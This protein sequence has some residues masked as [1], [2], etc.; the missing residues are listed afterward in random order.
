MGFNNCILMSSSSFKYL[1]LYIFRPYFS[2]CF[3][4]FSKRDARSRF[5]LLQGDS[6]LKIE[7]VYRGFV[8]RQ[9]CRAIRRH[10]EELFRKMASHHIFLDPQS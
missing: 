6:A 2:S 10:K 4:L 5:L 1:Y 8:A 9:R 3:D 7:R